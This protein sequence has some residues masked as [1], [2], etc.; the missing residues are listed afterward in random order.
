MTVPV[1][2][3]HRFPNGFEVVYLRCGS[4][5]VL[6]L[7]LW[8]RTGS[9]LERPGEEGLAH[10]VEHMLFK[11]TRR[12][13]P[14]A[15]A[16]EI[17]SLGGEINAYTSFDHTV[18]TAALASRYAAQGIDILFDAA[19][20]SL[21]AQTELDLE[22]QVILEE[23]KRARDLPQIHLSRLLF[24]ASYDG[25]PY[26]R[27]V[28]GTEESVRSFGRVDCLRF[29][30]RW[31][32]PSRMVLAAAGDLS[33]ETLLG[34]VAPAFGSMASRPGPRFRPVPPSAPRTRFTA[35]IEPREVAEVY[36]DLAF[37][38]LPARHPD[39][40]ALEVLMT[41]LGQGESSRL[42]ER[43]KLDR[44]LVHSIGA[45]AYCPEGPGLLYVG[46]AADSGMLEEALR[47]VCAEFGG[48]AR[49]PI[50][51]EELLRAKEHV[52]ADFVYERETVQG[53]AQK[54]GHFH[55][56]LG[57]VD[58]ERT[59]L[60]DVE[61]VEEDGLLRLARRFFDPSRA[62]FA[63]LHP[64]KGR[65]PLTAA[66]AERIFSESRRTTARRPRREAIASYPLPEGG[67]LLVR[68]NT[69]VPIVAFRAAFLGGL[70][71]EPA[72]K[73][74]G[75][76][77]L[78]ECLGRGTAHRTVFDIARESDRIGGYVEGFS[79][80]NSFGLKGE[81]L[82][83]QTETAFALLADCLL[84]PSFPAEEV[85]KAR[86]D[87]LAALRR[88]DDNP[89]SK[90]FRLFERT[91][92]GNHPYGRDVLGSLETVPRLTEGDLA[93][94]FAAH[95]LPDRFALALVGDVDPDRVAERFTTLLKFSSRRPGTAAPPPPDFPT[96]PRFE[97]LPSPHE[98]AHVVAGFPGATLSDRDRMALRV[99]NAMLSGQG[100][101]L[102]RALRDEQ[103]LAYSVFSTYLDGL[104]PG[105]L[106][107]YVATAPEN[108][109]AARDGLLREMLALA[110]GR[111]SA[112]E[113][114]EAKRKL[115]GGFE[116][117]LQENDFQASQMALDE[118]CGL[119][120]G[121]FLRYA[122]RVL[123][124]TPEAVAR[125]AGRFLR[126]ER[127]AAVILGPGN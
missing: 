99:I 119:G 105:Y 95:A 27:P 62:V 71:Q 102:F 26:G 58:H 79:G 2:Q 19:T 44:N 115:V 61:G 39:A 98:Q 106:A 21:F 100:G 33:F 63:M 4:A 50:G 30:E 7:D 74:G 124:V 91:L 56:V 126:P 64:K 67:R 77:L 10:V 18:Y 85:A 88:R 69:A 32:R 36:F 103:G 57:N 120:G 46:G 54:L 60:R 37:P 68:R 16:R 123:A 55:V 15:V 49:D 48:L 70:L 14:G 1:P 34:L 38:G 40:P 29:V 31:Y 45:G 28:I 13:P 84:G 111:F 12:R 83:K 20:D 81:F 97:R 25:H 96:A 66:K 75:F 127:H 109:L 94:L 80:R 8:V 41:V 65:P 92:Y 72:E 113:V 22:K 86:E 35:V 117:G 121:E 17:E 93:S 112:E 24:S 52:A 108:A 3:R 5:P 116:L 114:E 59:Y 118:V 53:Q 104:A 125:A 51:Q 23:I 73:A 110:Q 101:R 42:M 107:G 47:A 11:G 6:A 87:Q 89:M 9:A 82:S 43:V 122:R 76:H 90:A 78:A